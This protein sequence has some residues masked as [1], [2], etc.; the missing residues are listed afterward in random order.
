MRTMA[1]MAAF[2]P[3]ES[4]PEVNKAI[5]VTPPTLLFILEAQILKSEINNN[6]LKQEKIGSRLRS[7]LEKK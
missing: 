2:I 3:A 7:I 4:P 5:F 1:L 6:I